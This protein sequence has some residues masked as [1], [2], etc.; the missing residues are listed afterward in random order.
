MASK[1]ISQVLDKAGL[2]NIISQITEDIL[3]TR[4]DIMNTAVIGMRTRGVHIARRITDKINE[5]KGVSL[6]FGTLDVTFY[7]DDFRIR[8]KQ[9]NVQITDI[10]FI[11]DEKHLILVDDVLYSGRTIR[12]ALDA[13]MD[14][15]RPASIDLVV[16][17]DRGHRELPIQP[18]FVG[19]ISKTLPTE[20]IRV[21]IEEVDG[22]DGVYIIETP[23]NKKYME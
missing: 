4:L 12:A 15:G 13:L 7:R 10:P 18:N 14:F 6:D 20:E 11:I 22:E 5:I 3:K 16:L 21:M 19:K 2:E 9:P 8:L 1:I 17:V 23:K